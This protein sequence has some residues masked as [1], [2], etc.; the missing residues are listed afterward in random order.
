M[1]A[2]RR[3]H[4]RVLSFAA[5]IAASLLA[6]AP[7]RGQ[8]S[9]FTAPTTFGTSNFTNVALWN[10]GAGPVPPNGSATSN[11]IIQNFG[12]TAV[13]ATTDLNFTLQTLNLNS[14]SN[15]TM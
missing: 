3:P 9:T 11:L 6:T 7:A 15:S 10:F 12:T 2:I 1:I 14:F 5:A 4:C 13:T 8:T